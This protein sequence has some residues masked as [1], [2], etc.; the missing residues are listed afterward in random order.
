MAIQRRDF[1]HQITNRLSVLQVALS[2]N[3]TLN[4]LSLNMAAENFFRDVL[5][6][7]KG[8]DDL[9]NLNYFE[10][11]A[12]SIDLISVKNKTIIQVTST[13]T[14]AKLD[15]SL[16][17]L[18]E[19]RYKG[20]SLKILYLLELPNFAEKKR[21]YVKDEYNV[22][23]D[24]VVYGTKQL[25]EDIDNLDQTKLEQLAYDYFSDSG[26][27]YTTNSVLQL[28][29]HELV[30][31]MSKTKIERHTTKVEGVTEKAKTNKI[32]S[33]S[34]VMSALD[35]SVSYAPIILRNVSN[36]DLIKLKDLIVNQIYRDNL[37]NELTNY[38][39]TLNDIKDL[40]V[41]CLHNICRSVDLNTTPVLLAVYQVVKEKM[42][43][44][45]FNALHI[46]WVIIFTFF[47]ICDIGYI[48]EVSNDNAE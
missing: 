43:V 12:K 46:P 21:N 17:A 20:Y 42:L 8:W 23:V 34:K 36:T 30:K 27:R 15:A 24:D 47:E 44:Q 29:C 16:E 5:R 35:A 39:C 31:G 4:D 28:T 22:D 19:P 10:K 14:A 33:D 26:M 40:D 9:E 3:Q 37:I 11:C 1:I 45:D 41:N 18:D 48:G 13:R 38:G 6:I 32:I 25:I 2:Y 7:V